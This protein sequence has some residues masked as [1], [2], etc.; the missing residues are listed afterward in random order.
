MQSITHERSYSNTFSFEFRKLYEGKVTMFCKASYSPSNSVS[1]VL[2]LRWIWF[3]EVYQHVSFVFPR[4]TSF[5]VSSACKALTFSFRSLFSFRKDSISSS[6]S[7]SS[8]SRCSFKRSIIL[9]CEAIV[10]K[11]EVRTHQYM[12]HGMLQKEMRQ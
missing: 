6:L 3:Y 9:S 4:L 8:L 12:C 2:R 5:S 10:R 7:R 1:S 11:E